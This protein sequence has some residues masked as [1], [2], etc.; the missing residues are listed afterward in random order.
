M[1]FSKNKKYT[2]SIQKILI[3]IENQCRKYK[4][5]TGKI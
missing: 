5:E 3:K 4:L 2:I 1:C